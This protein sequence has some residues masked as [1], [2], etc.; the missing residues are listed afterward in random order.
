M[1]LFERHK[2]SQC[3][4]NPE[5]LGSLEINIVRFRDPKV[6]PWDDRVTGVVTSSPQISHNLAAA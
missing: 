1:D 5:T 4:A 2:S 3:E 6:K